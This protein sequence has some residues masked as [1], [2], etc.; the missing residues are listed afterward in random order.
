MAVPPPRDGGQSQDIHVSLSDDFAD[1]F[2][3]FAEWMLQNLG[4]DRTIDQ[5][6]RKA[7]VPPRTSA[8]RFRTDTGTTPAG[9]LNRERVIRAQ[10]LLEQ[11]ELSLETVAADTGFVATAELRNHFVKVL[12]TTPTA[13]RQAFCEWVRA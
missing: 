4:K 5:L 2:A 3:G 9:W 10:Q 7:L 8:R 11:T 6:A 1:S 13:Y 12:Q